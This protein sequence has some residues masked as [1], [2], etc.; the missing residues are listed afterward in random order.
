MIENTTICSP[1]RE[2]KRHFKLDAKNRQPTEEICHERRKSYYYIKSSKNAQPEQA[3]MLE[4]EKHE[5]G[6]INRARK[7]LADWRRSETPFGVTRTTQRLLQHWRD[8]IR[9]P[10]LFFC[11]IEAL[12]T[13]IYI[14]EIEA[15]YINEVEER[16]RKSAV[17]GE[18]LSVMLEKARKEEAT[19][20]LRIAFKMATGTGKTLVMSML[21]AYH[22]L[23]RKAEPKDKRFAES[24]LV[25][26]PNLTIKDRLEVLKPNSKNNYYQKH[27]LVPSEMMEEMRQATV[28]VTNYHTLQHKGMGD[29]SKIV[30]QKAGMQE[31][32][33]KENN[34]AMVKRVCSSLRG[35]ILVLNDEAHHCY[36]HQEQEMEETENLD[37][38][39]QEEA[40]ERKEKA[41]IWLKG[42]EAVQ[43]EREIRLVYDLSAT[44][45]YWSG[46]GKPTGKIFPWV[47][48]DFSLTEA[49]ESSIVK[50]PRMPLATDNP[51]KNYRY[52][53]DKI[54]SNLPARSINGQGGWVMPAQLDI[55][56]RA[57]YEKYLKDYNAWF[58]DKEK[59][60]RRGNIPPVLIVVCQNTGISRFVRDYIAGYERGEGRWEKGKLELFDNR[61]SLN[62]ILVDSKEMDNPKGL[63][64]AYKKEARQQIARQRGIRADKVRPEEILRGIMNTVG[65][66]GELGAKIRCVVSVAM[67]TEGWDANN[68]KQ[69]LGVRAFGSQ[70][71]CEQVVGR[72][73]RRTSYAPKKCN[74]DL[75]DGKMEEIDAFYPEYA[76]IYGIPFDLYFPVTSRP[77]DAP[78]PLETNHVRSLDERYEYE[79]RFPCVVGYVRT[80]EPVA[81][82]AS[83][84]DA[85][86]LDLTAIRHPIRFRV[87]ALVGSS[88]AEDVSLE[89]LKATREA[90]VVYALAYRLLQ[91]FKADAATIYGDNVEAWRFPDLLRIVRIWIRGWVICNEEH[92]LALLLIE[93]IIHEAVEKIYL[94]IEQPDEA[95][96][97]ISAQMEG[98][99]EYSTSDI[100]FDTTREVMETHKSHLSHM[101]ADTRT[102]EQKL[103]RLLEEEEQV[104][105]YVKNDP[106][107]NFSIPYEHAG[108]QAMYIPDFVAYVDD[109][110]GW[111]DPL[112]LII[113]VSGRHDNESRESKVS[114]VET[115]RKMWLPAVN[116]L[117]KF[118]R[119]DIVELR[120]DKRF[121]GDLRAFLA[122][123]KTKTL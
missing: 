67:L 25:V 44:P 90:R 2:P 42:L 110:A 100:A 15:R 50:V 104:L 119:W 73:L 72:A 71:L 113:E 43:K 22:Y 18:S 24:F 37:K 64:E 26:S 69:V 45:M 79:I 17:A 94:V 108:K 61:S 78:Q 91:R 121:G 120:D 58:A 20:L 77:Q 84:T 105:C 87:K 106:H 83:F 65:K 54:R 59:A 40:K 80:F 114:K 102:W 36:R 75:G 31:D 38:Q 63:N 117:K 33:F 66:E 39:E 52:F 98:F 116:R 115:T 107:L 1:F 55:V 103:A 12:E 8:K 51:D 53:W 85:S 28:V 92:F 57:L 16:K 109:G 11:Q 122:E 35:D 93:E 19:S 9:E 68:V 96:S 60:A 82:T 101:V 89:N 32:A 27:K 47:V 41:Q 86:R 56:L 74:V 99:V 23:N 118:G 111:E 88:E 76:D 3:D 62:T 4:G 46:S 97:C 30:R 70:L 81:L 112:K 10:R 95:S 21:I 48:S 49:I 6:L 13:A 5:H 14:N 123:R 34:A 7:D 29:G